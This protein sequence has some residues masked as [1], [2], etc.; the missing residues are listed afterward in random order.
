MRRVTTHFTNS[1]T[2]D[3]PPGDVFAFVAD[4]ENVPEWNYAI[5]ETRKV[6]DGPVSVGTAYRQV[7]SLPERS[8]ETLQVAEMLPD[9]RFVVQG[10]IGPFV[11]SLAYD[12]EDIGGRTRLTNT[13]DLEGRV[14]MKLA[15]QV[16]SAR[17]RDA[18]SANLSTL[19][20]LL[21][22]RS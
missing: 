8:E 12:V 21:E 14:L 18:V 16:T 1:I 22:S 11:G 10:Q 20:Q 4:L 13:V 3:R 2:I 9:R 6:S 7:R 5:V 15:G 19:K 17:V